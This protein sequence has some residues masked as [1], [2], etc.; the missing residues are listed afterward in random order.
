MA[1]ERCHESLTMISIYVHDNEQD[2]N[3][4]PVKARNCRIILGDISYAWMVRS[5]LL[6]IGEL[7]PK[8]QNGHTSLGD[9]S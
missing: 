5:V 6:T 7:F 1:A 8:A 9:Y 4:A 2:I 3:T